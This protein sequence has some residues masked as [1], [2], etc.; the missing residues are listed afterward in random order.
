MFNSYAM[1]HDERNWK[2]PEDFE[3]ERFL[4]ENGEFYQSRVGFMPF[5]AGKRICLGESIAKMELTLILAYLLQ[6]FEFQTDG[7]VDLEGVQGASLKPKPYK[8]RIVSRM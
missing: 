4:D 7:D 3:P 1:N 2:N 8:L 6:N 5:S